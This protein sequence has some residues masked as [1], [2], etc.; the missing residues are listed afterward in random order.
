MRCPL[1]SPDDWPYDYDDDP[2]WVEPDDTEYTELEP[3]DG[4]PDTYPEPPDEPTCRNC[5]K[6][7]LNGDSYCSSVCE[8]MDRWPARSDERG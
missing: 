3:P 7:L 1:E 6:P 2:R 4:P 8:D 5:D